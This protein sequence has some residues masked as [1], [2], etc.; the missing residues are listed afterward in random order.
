M[1]RKIHGTFTSSNALLFSAQETR[2]ALSKSKIT[3]D[4][5]S[6]GSCLASILQDFERKVKTRLVGVAVVE[7]I[8]GGG[9]KLGLWR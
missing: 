7:L 5:L 3:T 9:V 8:D 2:N 6:H 1:Y 4:L